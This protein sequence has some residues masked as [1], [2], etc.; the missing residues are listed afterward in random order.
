MTIKP[1]FSLPDDHEIL[2][3][4]VDVAQIGVCFMDEGGIFLRANQVFCDMVGYRPDEIIGHTW[5]KLIPAEWISRADR[6]LY[7]LF[8]ESSGILDEWK[9]LHK[10][11][12]QITTLVRFRTDTSKDG[13]RYQVITF[14]NIDQRKAAE[15][16]A[17]QRSEDLYRKVVENVSEGII[18]RLGDRWV[19]TNPRTCELTGYTSL[20]MANM[21][22]TELVSPEDLAML[23]ERKN[24]RNAGQEIERYM[25]FRLLRKDGTIV[26]V[27]ASTV[28]I[29]WGGQPATLS[30]LSDLTERR[31][32]EEAIIKSEQHYREVV[33]NVTEGLIVVQD[34]AIAF[35]NPRLRELTGY[36]EESPVGLPFTVLMHADDKERLLDNHRRRLNGESVEQHY[37]CRLLNRHT[38]TA[39]WAEL[40][41]VRIE[42]EG[43]PATLS[44]IT[45][46][47][48]R[49]ELEN[50]LKQSVV[51]RD[52]ILENSVVGMSFLDE[53]GNVRWGNGALFQILGGDLQSTIGKSVEMYYPTHDDYVKTSMEIAEA[54]QQGVSYEK[55]LRLRRGDQIPFWAYMSGRAVNPHD[56]SQGT[57]WIVMDISKRRDLEQQQEHSRQVISNVTECI[58]VVQGGKIVFSNPRVEKLTG[59]SQQE[60][61]TQPFVTAIHPEDRPMVIDHHQRRLRGENVQEYYQFRI[62]NQTTSE[63]RW[64]ELSAVMIDWEGSTATLSF[65]TDITE[66][67]K[68]EDN[69]R[70]STMERARLEKLQI[71]NELKEAEMA[72]RHAEETTAAKSMFLANMSH[73]IRTPMNAIIGMAH[74]ALQTEL[75]VK[76]RD[77]VEKIHG[78]GISL[79]G[80]INDILDFSKIEAGKLDI[81]R[82]EFSLDVVL[83]NVSTVT[84]TKAH[85]KGL[86]YLF[87]ISPSTPRNLIGDP[88]RLGQVLINLIN[89]AIKFTESGEVIVACRQLE[90]TTDHPIQLEFTVHDTGIGMSQEQSEKLF[91]AF[92]QADESTT[93]KYGGTGLGLSIS[94]GMVELMGGAI[95]L[96]SEVG[97]GTSIRFTAGFGVGEG[98]VPRRVIPDDINGM[99]I[100]VV[101]DNPAA[102]II[103]AEN[104]SGLPVK[105]DQ[106]MSGR[107]ALA[108][109]RSNDLRH[110]YG[111]V[112]TDMVMPE[113]DGL[114][115]IHEVKK[116]GTIK[117]I[118]K[119]VLVSAYGRSDYQLRKENDLSDDFLMKPVSP[120]MM[121]DALIGLYTTTLDATTSYV[122]G[123]AIHF[124]DLKILLVED[125]EINQQ[126]A[127]ELMESAG[128]TVEVAGNGRIAVDMLETAGP[129]QY[130]L[131]FMDVQMPEMDGHTATRY[132]RGMGQ[133]K[134]I[135]IIAMTAHAMVEERDR[136]LVSGMNDHLSKPIDPKELYRTIAK[137]CPSHVDHAATNISEAQ[138]KQE[139]H[140]IATDLRIEGI[141]VQDGLRRMLG[142]RSFYMQMLTRFHE[143]QENIVAEIIGALDDSQDQRKAERLAHTLKSVAGQLGIRAVNEMAAQA[144]GIIRK[145][146]DRK[147]LMPLLDCLD[148]ELKKIMRAL[149]PH[150]AASEQREQAEPSS[151][152]P[153]SHETTHA[154]IQRIVELLRQYDG[155]AIELLTESNDV[156]A[157]SLSKPAHQKVMRAARQFDFDAGLSALLEGAAEAGFGAL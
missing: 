104:L 43:R 88:L 123:A 21:P 142:N 24:R 67:R 25:T 70:Q 51:E 33:N 125:N 68:L 7:K 41:A 69:L 60:L 2:A 10:N 72:R 35:I 55:E 1:A 120:S 112:F 101:D 154:L 97:K 63:I 53:R 89:N 13:K 71:Q 15:Q 108:V 3:A 129:D 92:S 147:L 114:D 4:A 84:S 52:I 9:I 50:R 106:V 96:Q 77:Y 76:Q 128:I 83:E 131:V 80:I 122:K 74:L 44:F 39:I 118:P 59:M 82:V 113:M 19:F 87:K 79:L 110:P 23:T 32:Q 116:S 111:V 28:A 54:I 31:K 75:N 36:L 49:K 61:A 17:L 40:S 99:R 102:C 86:E 136:C 85:E 100:L 105:V 146:E 133:F 27:E 78:A 139:Q 11:G 16:Q 81:E 90:A 34:L 46:I 152:A 37:E 148:T 151:A 135:P 156:L 47:S 157:K 153:I 95:T 144:E 29:T 45:D 93:R 130:G 115:L 107:A 18:V 124:K 42:W 126:I 57:V 117:N 8:S 150:L 141:D 145:G 98:K 56:P 48:H 58:L 109:I 103:M 132:I 143:G 155:D 94:K 22:Y 26:W 149:A 6:F 65:M 66:R 5:V 62:V 137:W 12:T 140:A 30:F 127:R 138:P 64:V 14:I 73:E 121:I 134:K 38:G 20:E 119:M 91:R